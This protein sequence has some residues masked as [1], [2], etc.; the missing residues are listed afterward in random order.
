M[1]LVLKTAVS[2]RGYTGREGQKRKSAPP[3]LWASHHLSGFGFAG[4]KVRAYIKL[5]IPVLGRMWYT[6]SH[7]NNHPVSETASCSDS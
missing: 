3:T 1:F 4:G 2:T 5:I 6:F 7:E